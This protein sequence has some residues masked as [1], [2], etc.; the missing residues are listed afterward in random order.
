MEVLYKLK[1]RTTQ[2]E[3][4]YDQLT[5]KLHS[6]INKQT[7]LLSERLIKQK[8]LLAIKLEYWFQFPVCHAK[9]LIKH[10]FKMFAAEIKGYSTF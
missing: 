5:V 4:Q 3:N 10:L 9:I 6:R 2:L 1:R 8:L 7:S